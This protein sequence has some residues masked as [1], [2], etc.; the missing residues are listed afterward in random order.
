MQESHL[1]ARTL[2]DKEDSN[3][4]SGLVG[5]VKHVGKFATS[6]DDAEDLMQASLIYFHRGL[7][8]RKP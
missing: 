7:P 8:A 2:P 4:Q 1:R 6:R 5:R 3:A